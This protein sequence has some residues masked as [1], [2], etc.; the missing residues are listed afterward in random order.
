MFTNL[1]DVMNA[2]LDGVDADLTDSLQGNASPLKQLTAQVR[3][4][5][6]TQIHSQVEAQLKPLEQ[7]LLDITLNWQQHPTA[8]SIKVRALNVDVLPAAKAQ[9]KGNPL[10]NLQI[11]NAACAPVAQQAAAP[12]AQADAP[13]SLPTAVSAGLATTPGDESNS[14]IVKAALAMMLAGGTALVVIRWLHA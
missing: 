6:V 5:I 12:A 10:V 11:G 14:G 4:Q 1:S 8:D 7:N 2:I 9:L 3:T 13:K